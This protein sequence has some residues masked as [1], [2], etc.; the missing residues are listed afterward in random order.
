MRVGFIYPLSMFGLVNQNNMIDYVLIS[1]G[2]SL[3]GSKIAPYGSGLINHTYK[4]TANNQNYILQEINTNI[5]KAPYHIVNNLALIGTYISE[6]AP[7]YLFVAPLKSLNGDFIVKA[8]TGG[9]YRLFPFVQGSHS[10]D[11]LKNEKEAYEAAKEFGKFTYLLKDFDIGL[12]EYPLQNFHDLPLRFDQFRI[13]VKN[14]DTARQE[15]ATAEVNEVY[16]HQH[17]LETYNQLITGQEIPMRVVHH[18][19]KISNILF[20]DQ[21]NA[22]CLVDLDT[23]MPGYYL[24]DVGDMMRT[25]LSP[26]N[27]E[28]KD[29]DKVY[30]RA[31]FFRAIY[32]GYLSEM[33]TIL[34]KTENEHF[35]FSGKMIIY[36]QALRFLTDFL[37]NDIYYGAKYPGHNLLRAKNQFK[38][39]N[40]YINAEPAFNELID[41]VNQSS[42]SITDYKYNQTQ[43]L[44]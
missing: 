17:I 30:I 24:S 18:D 44:S 3:I 32:T 19:T 38:L 39:L 16:K 7:G 42:H 22:L 5:F 26:A 27:E 43:P 12:L 8:A 20:D 9:H 41:E 6:T 25:Y 2:L 35:I 21:Q 14:T 33:G 36:M 37:N 15:Q 34:T 13:A 31:D 28:E 23:V 11:V 10:V 40:E 4:L 29:L 1:Y